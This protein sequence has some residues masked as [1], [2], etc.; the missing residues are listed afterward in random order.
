MLHWWQ[1]LKCL[2]KTELV[3]V[4]APKA[5]ESEKQIEK[6][7]WKDKCPQW[8]PLPFLRMCEGSELQGFFKI[9][10]WNPCFFLSVLHFLSPKKQLAAPGKGRLLW[11]GTTFLLPFHWLGDSEDQQQVSEIRD[12]GSPFLQ[13]GDNKRDRNRARKQSG[14]SSQRE[15]C[16]GEN[17]SLHMQ[18]TVSILLLPFVLSTHKVCSKEL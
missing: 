12:L 3:K 15:E 17:N 9:W 5:A 13:D 1:P 14:Q 11:D 7:T 2:Q 18:W 4:T 6:A 10:K 8:L 16:I